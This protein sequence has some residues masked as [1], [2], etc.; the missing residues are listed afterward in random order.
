[1]ITVIIFCRKI[2]SEEM[3]PRVANIGGIKPT[4]GRLSEVTHKAVF[5]VRGLISQL[6]MQ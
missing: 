5:T 2:F 3:W 1:M 6:S 4:T